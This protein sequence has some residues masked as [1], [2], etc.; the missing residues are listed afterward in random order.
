LVPLD[1][2]TRSCALVSS[3]WAKAVATI[4]RNATV[5]LPEFDARVRL[6]QLEDFLEQQ[7]EQLAALDVVIYRCDEKERAKLGLCRDTPFFSLS[8]SKLTELFCVR[9]EGL[10]LQIKTD[11]R[12]PGQPQAGASCSQGTPG[13]G[14]VAAIGSWLYQSA[15]G[16]PAGS[17]AAAAVAAAAAAAAEL[18][19]DQSL[20]P[21][22]LA[23]GFPSMAVS[24]PPAAVPVA[25]V[26]AAA[27]MPA[28]ALLHTGGQ[29]AADRLQLQGQ[30]GASNSS[31]SSSSSSNNNLQ[32]PVAPFEEAVRMPLLPALRQLKLVNCSISLSNFAQLSRMTNLT[33][34]E[35]HGLSFPLEQLKPV[36]SS[37]AS[38][39]LTSILNQLTGL[40][41]LTVGNGPYLDGAGLATMARM[42]QLQ[43]VGLRHG[44]CQASTLAALSSHIRSLRLGGGSNSSSTGSQTCDIISVS[45]E[46]WCELQSA[47]TSRLSNLQEL[48]LTGLTVPAEI[49]TARPDLPRLALHSVRAQE[50]SGLLAKGGVPALGKLMGLQ[51]LQLTDMLDLSLHTDAALRELQSMFVVLGQ[52]TSLHI[53]SSSSARIVGTTMAVAAFG[54]TSS[55]G[56]AP[57][58]CE[59][60][61]PRCLPQLKILTLETLHDCDVDLEGFTFFAAHYSRLDR[62]DITVQQPCEP[63]AYGKWQY[64]CPGRA[65]P[66]DSCGRSLSNSTFALRMRLKD[67][68][69]Y[70]RECGDVAAQWVGQCFGHVTGLTW[71]GQQLS[72]VA[73]EHLTGLNGVAVAACGLT[74]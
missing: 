9:L 68:L 71:A 12:R 33:S 35:V 43:R 5:R 50:G 2:R 49:F 53:N 6:Q 58:T 16:A 64:H 24:G 31:S 21:E 10:D 20:Q 60:L 15:L 39:T 27:A 54:C 42:P 28:A 7:G 47:L 46:F 26:A 3:Y 41:E 67:L 55:D 13:S 57:N 11:E 62:L 65:S 14:T 19:D 37:R 61:D 69:L 36:S 73:H 38:A 63:G 8:C 48:K 17:A 70:G 40:S 56:T 72:D 45:S 4:S 18:F 44:S 29:A 66:N 23:A 30:Q 32:L 51:H 74:K 1:Q 59:P 25:Q 34:L 22:G 52:L